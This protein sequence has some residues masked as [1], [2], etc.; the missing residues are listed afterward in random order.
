MQKIIFNII[1]FSVMPISGFF[2]IKNLIKSDEK[3]FSI[4][5]IFIL[6]LLI[7][8]N[9]L[10][11]NIDYKALITLLNF[12][13]I[14]IGY[15]FIFKISMFDSFLLSIILMI[16]VF[17]SDIL[18]YIIMVIFSLDSY[19]RTL[20]IITIIGN[21]LVGVFSILFSIIPKTKEITQKLLLRL[22]NKTKLR[23]ISLSL[24]WIVVISMLCYSIFFSKNG[25]FGFWISIII[26]LV[27]IAFLINYFCEKNKYISL[28]ER[29]DDLFNYIQTIED[30]L[31]EEQLNIHEYKNQ[32]TVIKNMTKENKIKKY[33]DSLTGND[34][35]STEWNS[36]LKKLPKG[37]F[38]GLLYYKCAQSKQKKLDILVD[39]DSNVRS[40]F[41]RMS[42]ENTKTLSRLVG[43]YLDNAIEA[44]VNT[45]E[46]SISV[47]IYLKHNKVNIVISNPFSE[48]IDLA[49]INKKG[50]SSKGRGRGRGLYFA[51]KIAKNSNMFEVSNSIINNYYV[52]R[53]IIN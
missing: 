16:F 42:L 53:I 14:V 18:L 13:A 28:N 35:V 37:G 49:K 7:L 2:V 33:I 38:K 41:E 50:Y 39:I 30:A 47:E 45:K 40:I 29:F 32:L 19:M 20:G 22:E 44:S 51:S 34:N 8:F 10:I 25:S 48:K 24:L 27:F 52:Q 31:D 3:I 12:C 5:N 36:T 23:A 4:K 1:I 9:F 17:V 26:E 43:I 11:Y 15:K 46:K 6:L 21:I